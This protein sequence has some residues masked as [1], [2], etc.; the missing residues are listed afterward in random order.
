MRAQIIVRQ[1]QPRSIVQ[2]FEV[3]SLDEANVQEQLAR[4][5]ERYPAEDFE[6]DTSQVAAVRAH[7]HAAVEL[8]RVLGCR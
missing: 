6:L 4:L 2:F 1:K 8:S 5:Q 3:T 7:C